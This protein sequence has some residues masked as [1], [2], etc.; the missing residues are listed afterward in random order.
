MIRK[1][2]G[3]FEGEEDP[4]NEVQRSIVLVAQRM[5]VFT[6]IVEANEMETVHHG[7]IGLVWNLMQTISFSYVDLAARYSF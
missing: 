4:G 5:E 2:C 1:G 3:A 7:V 6:E